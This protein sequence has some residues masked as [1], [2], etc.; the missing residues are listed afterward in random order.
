MQHSRPVR[1][2]AI[3]FL[4]TVPLLAQETP[5]APG[6]RGGRRGP[7]AKPVVV[8][9][10]VLHPVSGP[11]IENG[12]LVFAGNQIQAVG[13]E[14]EVTIPPDAE[15]H[16]H[17]QAHAYPGLIDALCVAFQEEAP[18]D[19]GTDAGS[20]QVSG[21]DPYERGS[22]GLL[23]AGITTA[24]IVS[25]AN[26]MWR[27]IAP[28]VRATRERFAPFQPRP[29]AGVQMRATSGPSGGHALDRAKALRGLGDAF[30]GL[31]EYEKAQA[32]HKKALDEYT[33]KR[34]EFLAWHRSRNPAGA[35]ASR[36]A[37]AP[38]SAPESA[39]ATAAT[40]PAE[41]G[42]NR[43]QGGPPGPG[44]E[45]RGRFPRGEGGRGGV[46]G[47]GPGGAP[48]PG[49]PPPAGQEPA[50][51]AAGRGAPAGGEAPKKPEYPKTPQK[52]PAREALLKVSK[53]DLALRI[54]AHRPEE[55]R[56]A[57]QLARERNLRRVV[58]E[59]ASEAGPIAKEIA[60]AGVPVVV[61]AASREAWMPETVEEAGASPVA[62]L[63][64]RLHEAGVSF[65]I[66]S[67]QPRQWRALPLLVAESVGEGLPADAALRAITLGAAEVL[68]IE[69]FVG[70][71]ERGK[72]ADVVLT[73]GPLFGSDSQVVKV[74]SAGQVGY[75]VSR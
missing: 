73:S 48:Q 39:P 26:T 56:A 40:R 14:G 43:P 62:G 21:L 72:V 52:D 74:F 23:A 57:L 59:Y 2:W 5:D 34:G 28:V 6:A 12:V 55:I 46:P 44:G 71:L 49:T 10:G 13:K 50:G 51:A 16:E 33:K 69:R 3:A 61:A 11:A 24:A 35:T 66:G 29:E 58:L 7:R 53:G 27:G 18:Q 67:G 9:V 8:K 4:L 36:P 1:S 32:D 38:A 37:S 31:E 41:G 20:E 19:P 65:A 17:P 42:E 60:E 54:E 25:R 63:H 30:E 15:V 75:E 64:R 22:R 70:S 68:G 45:R 47:G